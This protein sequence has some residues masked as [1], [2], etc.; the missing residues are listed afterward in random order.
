MP[1][2]RLRRSG[3]TLIELLVVIAIIA[4]LIG[5]LLPAVQKVREAA[6]RARCQNNL[7]QIMLATLAYE[8]DRRELPPGYIA[9]FYIGTLPFLLPYVEQTAIANNVANSGTGTSAAGIAYRGLTIPTEVPP[10]AALI[11]FWINAGF[12]NAGAPEIKTF[13]CPSDNPK[14]VLRAFFGR[15]GMADGTGTNAGVTVTGT[16]GAGR[17][18]YGSNPGTAGDMTYAP[19]TSPNLPYADYVGPFTVNSRTKIVSIAD[20]TSNTIGFGETFLGI[21]PGE[22][23]T[24]GGWMNMTQ[25]G[26]VYGF[27]S[28]TAWFTYGSAHTGIINFAMCD[29]SVRP[30]QNNLATGTV[31]TPEWQQLQ[32]WAGYRDGQVNDSTF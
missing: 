25:L 20:G 22:R 30:F 11:T 28:P 9:S 6:S 23:D 12:G 2:S 31:G 10:R 16:Y 24:A 1:R 4:I 17:T 18:N 14:A 8:S 7:K 19:A 27:R 13:L 15:A 5:L 26:F 29:G 3:F 21:Y 32:N